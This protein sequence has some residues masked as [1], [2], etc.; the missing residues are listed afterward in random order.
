MVTSRTPVA[1][2][3]VVLTLLLAYL[4]GWAGHQGTDS[5]RSS[6][7]EPAGSPPPGQAPTPSAT[8]G[9]DEP[10]TQA[11]AIHQPITG[12]GRPPLP[13]EQAGPFGARR[14]TGAGYAALTFDDG[15]DP[16]WT[17]QVLAI[18]REHRVLATFCVV[19]TNVLAFP[20]LVREIADDGH[21][22]CNHS[23]SHDVGLGSRSRVEIRKDL[24]RTNRAIR[25]AA[26]GSRISYYR[27]PGGAWTDRVV[28]AAA[29]LGMTS[30]HWAVDPQD[31]RRPAARSIAREVVD[32]TEPGAIVLLHDGGGDRA[33]T[34]HAL[35][36]MLP[37]LT[38]DQ[39]LAAPPPG[40]PDW[41]QDSHQMS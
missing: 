9:A 35:T 23:W 17:P 25:Q 11:A 2:A 16:R 38:A 3:A 12:P 10:P 14:T 13:F 22:M 39:D 18:L 36:L 1:V 31:W 21:T 19:G 27:Q 34:V 4:A 33:Q 37:R 40:I 5:L 26:P 30:L 6:D 32:G 20:E 24:E 7:P 8:P 15:P 41:S 29:E 28:A